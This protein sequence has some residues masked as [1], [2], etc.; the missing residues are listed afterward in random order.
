MNFPGY[1]IPLVR[2]PSY[3][4]IVKRVSSRRRPHLTMKLR[5][6]RLQDDLS[7]EA[8]NRRTGRQWR[9]ISVRSMN[10]NQRCSEY[11][12]RSFERE[13]L[14]LH[15]VVRHGPRALKKLKLLQLAVWLAAHRPQAESHASSPPIKKVPFR[16]LN[17]TRACR[18]GVQ[19]ADDSI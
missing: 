7:T 4:T 14:M 3:R 1:I 12:C 17:C 18:V 2:K 6:E 9:S 11:R 5:T 19:L 15:G 16:F 8:A 10:L 13:H